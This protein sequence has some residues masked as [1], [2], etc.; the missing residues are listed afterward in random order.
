[1]NLSL[2]NR[3]EVFIIRLEKVL[4]FEADDHYTRVQCITGS[5]FMVPF[6]LS[7]I[8]ERLT[9]ATEF[10]RIGRSYIVN[11]TTIRH[12]SA[13]KQTV[14]FGDEPEHSVTLHLSRPMIRSL[15]NQ[16]APKK[17]KTDE[18]E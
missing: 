2:S 8:Q 9:E 11:T 3:D 6:N 18:N 7:T 14:T 1:M 5:K 17:G 4:F 10:L 13:T 16:L 15:M 12:L